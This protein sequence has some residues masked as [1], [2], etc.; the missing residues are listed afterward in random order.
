MGACLDWT[1]LDYCISIS[2]SQSW[3]RDPYLV[4]EP[5]LGPVFPDNPLPHLGACVSFLP[6][7]QYPYA[8]CVV[9]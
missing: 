1:S 7:K 9:G 6:E 4:S 3:C 5:L 8:F 2:C